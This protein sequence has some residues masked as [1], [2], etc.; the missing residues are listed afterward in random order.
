MQIHE[1]IYLYIYT[2]YYKL[3]SIKRKLKLI[4]KIREK[5]NKIKNTKKL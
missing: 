3:K 1:Y 5:W 4:Y 2:N